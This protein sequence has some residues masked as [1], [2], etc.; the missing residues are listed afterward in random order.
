MKQPVDYLFPPVE[1]GLVPYWRLVLRGFSQICFQS[2]ELT[3]LFFFVAVLVAS[4]I[5]AA[6]LLVAG[7]IAPAGRMLMG[8]RAAFIATGLPG[9]NPG[10]IALALPIF[11]ETGWTNYGMWAALVVCVIATLIVV[12]L[13]LAIL[14]FPALALPFLIVFW[15]LYAL[16]PYLDVVQPIS[17]ASTAPAAFQPVTALL[18]SLG[19]AIFSPTALSGALFAIGVFLSNWRHAV[20]A[21]CG[22]VI[23]TAVAYYYRDVDA[24]SANLGLYGFNGVLT[25]VSVFVVCGGKLRLAIFGALVATI[26]TPAISSLG[27]QSLSAPFVFTTWLMLGLGWIED[28]WFDVEPARAS[29]PRL[30]PDVPPRVAHDRPGD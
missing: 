16:A 20:L 15:V 11:F 9:L 4:P 17:F 10:L 29:K 21:V 5:S 23:G 30:K 25:A 1:S 24:G 19:Q 27:L 18:L 3:G 6:Y 8:D 22:A 12:E 26:L 7:I 2:N 14:P 13:C 28:N